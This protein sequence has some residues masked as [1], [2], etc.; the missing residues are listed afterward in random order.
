MTSQKVRLGASPRVETYRVKLPSKG[1][2]RKAQPLIY[3]EKRRSSGSTQT[4]TI[5]RFEAMGNA[6][7]RESRDRC[8][9]MAHGK[10]LSRRWRARAMLEILRPLKQ[11]AMKDFDLR[12]RLLRSPAQMADHDPKNLIRITRH[13]LGHLTNSS[14]TLGHARELRPSRHTWRA[15]SSPRAKNCSQ[16][17]TARFPC[18]TDFQRPLGLTA[19]ATRCRQI[20]L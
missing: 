15:P 4:A 5:M 3:N 14:L 9:E 19:L 12:S 6:R 10:L 8:P 16:P 13:A 2:G 1:Y 17:E 20:A 11:R 7:N 18:R